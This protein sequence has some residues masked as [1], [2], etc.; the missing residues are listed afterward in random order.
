MEFWFGF[1]WALERLKEGRRVARKGWN[2]KGM[3]IELQVPDDRSK[4]TLPYLFIEYPEGH[5][6][7]PK[8]CRVP[9]LAS[10]TD[11]I[12]EDWVIAEDDPARGEGWGWA[13]TRRRPIRMLGRMPDVLSERVEYL[14][15]MATAVAHDSALQMWSEDP[16][17]ALV[18]GSHALAAEA[19]SSKGGTHLQRVYPKKEGP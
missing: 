9:W 11:L 16:A 18:F 7:Y 4:M 12:A 6:A 2:G 15:T 3:W 5:P 1:G 8:G 14:T 17:D 10:Q 19:A 13:V